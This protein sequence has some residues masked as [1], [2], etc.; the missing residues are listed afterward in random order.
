MIES[1][2]LMGILFNFELTR[3]VV[4]DNQISSYHTRLKLCSSLLNFHFQL[5]TSMIS[6]IS[7]EEGGAGVIV[8]RL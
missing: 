8:C 4:L 5:S 3:K 6:L 7:G 1:S 2:K